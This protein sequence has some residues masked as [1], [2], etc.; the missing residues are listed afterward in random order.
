IQRQE[1]RGYRWW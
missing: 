1:N